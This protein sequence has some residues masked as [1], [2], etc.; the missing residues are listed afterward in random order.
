MSAEYR[1]SPLDLLDSRLAAGDLTP[2]AYRREWRRIEFLAQWRALS[3]AAG[4]GPSFRRY[5]RPGRHVGGAR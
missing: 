2:G 1:T 4:M 3:L 5:M